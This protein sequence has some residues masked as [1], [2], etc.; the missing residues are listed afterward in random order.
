MFKEK[1]IIISKATNTQDYIK[2]HLNTDEELGKQE[3]CKGYATI[4]TP[5]GKKELEENNIRA[6]K[7]TRMIYIVKLQRGLVKKIPISMVII[8]VRQAPSADNWE[9]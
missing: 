7:V 2:V 5:W 9:L 1:M 4:H 6:F 3:Q 8:W